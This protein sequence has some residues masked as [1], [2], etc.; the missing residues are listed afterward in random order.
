MIAD[1]WTSVDP[2]WNEYFIGLASDGNPRLIPRNTYVHKDE[3]MVEI[4]LQPRNGMVFV[5]IA[6]PPISSKRVSKHY[7]TPGGA[8]RGIQK[9]VGEFAAIVPKETTRATRRRAKYIELL[10]NGWPF[11]KPTL[12]RRC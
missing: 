7:M 5:D 1:G 9:M 2:E 8:A 3:V 4:C 11:P 10:K 12:S 6:R